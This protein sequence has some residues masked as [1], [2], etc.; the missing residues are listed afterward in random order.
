KL[1]N[2]ARLIEQHLADYTPPASAAERDAAL[3]NLRG[4]DRALIAWLQELVARATASFERYDYPAA[5]DATERFFW[6]TFCDNYLEWVKGRLYDGSG[7]GRQSAQLALA[8]TLETLLKLLAPIMPHI[9][10]E[11]YQQLFAPASGARSIHTS[12]WPATSAALRDP[13]AERVGAALLAIT[14]AARRF[15]SAQQLGLGAP[16]APLSIAAGELAAPP[17]A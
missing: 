1:W 9:T 6:N 10:E 14:A 13:E 12:A 8:H 5:L 4:T 15:K 3:A 16:L 11:I 7:A 2:A 17:A